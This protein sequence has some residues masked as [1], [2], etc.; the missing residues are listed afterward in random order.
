MDQSRTPHSLEIEQAVLGGIMAGADAWVPIAGILQP[1]HFC[2]PLHGRIYAVIIKMAS[3][4]C[5][6]SL[7]MVKARLDGDPALQEIGGG[8]YLVSLYTMAPPPVVLESHAK[9][10]RELAERRVA[11]ESCTIAI[12]TFSDTGSPNFRSDLS[13]HL[14]TITGVFDGVR[15]R[16]TCFTIAESTANAIDRLTR[17]RAGESDPNAITTRI[18]VLDAITG[19][20]H[21]GEY[22]VVG[23][24]PSMGKT[25]LAVQF[26]MNIAETGGGVA[27]FSLE[28]PEALLSPRLL[29]SKLWHSIRQEPTYQALLMG[30]VSDLEARY[31]ADAAEE[32]RNWPLYIE[33]EPGLTA[34]EIEARARVIASKLS[35]KGKTLDLLI[36][37]HIHKCRHPGAQSKVTELTEISARLAEA[38]KRLDCPVIAL[39]QLNRGVESREDKRPSLSDLR[40]S[41]AIEQDADLVAF[42]YR[43]AYYLERQSYSDNNREADRIADLMRCQNRMELIIAKQRSGPIG[44]IDLWVNMGCNKV[45]DP[46][47]APL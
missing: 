8:E 11:I 1:G 44:T 4:R 35:A 22:I 41:G 45:L 6:P 43:E 42:V 28:M 19:G 23:A 2:E 24:R 26:A 33:D 27:Y 34:A 5:E 10:L 46:S 9:L 38:A 12:D 25:A 32:M 18:P 20:L 30:Q 31:A 21:R 7:L 37:D 47:E 16:Q 40:E 15:E 29:G 17:L 3:E 14:E 13:R 36:V 39:A